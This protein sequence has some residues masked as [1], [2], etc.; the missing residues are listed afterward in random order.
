MIQNVQ[1]VVVDVD[2]GQSELTTDGQLSMKKVLGEESDLVCV[3]PK[4]EMELS[5]GLHL[6]LKNVVGD[7]S[8]Q[9]CVET[10]VDGE[11]AQV[12]NLVHVKGGKSDLV[13]VEPKAETELPTG[14]HLSMENVIGDLSDLVC[15]ETK[16]GIE[17]AQVCKQVHAECKSD[18]VSMD[19][20][21]EIEL[22]TGLQLS[23]KNVVGGMSDLVYAET[24][25][26][27]QNAQ[28]CNLVNVEGGKS[29]LVTVEP[30]FLSPEND[31][32]IQYLARKT[33]IKDLEI[34]KACKVVVESLEYLMKEITPS[35]NNMWDEAFE[36][37]FG[38]WKITN[39]RFLNL[40]ERKQKEPA[41]E[42]ALLD[43]CLS[44]GLLR[45]KESWEIGLE[46]MLKMKENKVKEIYERLKGSR[47]KKKKIELLEDCKE[48][49]TL[50]IRNPKLTLENREQ[51]I[52]ANLKAR[53]IMTDTKPNLAT[54]LVK[55]MTQT[56]GED[57]L[58]THA[59]SKSNVR[60]NFVTSL[61]PKFVANNPRSKKTTAGWKTTSSPGKM[62]PTK[63]MAGK[64]TA[65]TKNSLMATSVA[66]RLGLKSLPSVRKMTD[67]LQG[68]HLPSAQIE[69]NFQFY[70]QDMISCS[71][72]KQPQE[73][74]LLN[75]AGPP[76]RA[77]QGQWTGVQA[78]DQPI[79]A[80]NEV[81]ELP[82]NSGD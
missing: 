81:E 70:K 4:I 51:E 17:D 67:R 15:E 77:K 50:E 41:K 39:G 46:N 53:I 52:Y 28:V 19:T 79:G 34:L 80:K 75:R 25:V 48:T 30:K 61:E 40:K 69:A 62:T 71:T 56:D 29:D 63:K 20:K 42:N 58:G 72:V 3:D 76:M 8:D 1:M 21:V 49:L 57:D 44:K 18:L 23:M 33:A 32:Q 78:A 13:N 14:L 26:E 10:R 74:T 27:V 5:R 12:C 55:K 73:C 35:M 60:K 7:V 31:N 37:K 16:V 64:M 43:F 82:I 45:Q 6:S 11:N 2:G 24:R 47:T 22:P 9:V 36:R 59:K 66:S 65:K 54:K 68:T 38:V